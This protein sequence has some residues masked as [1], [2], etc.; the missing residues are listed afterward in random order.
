MSIVSP[1][2]VATYQALAPRPADRTPRPSPV[3]EQMLDQLRSLGYV[4]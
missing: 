2:P 1:A 4:Q 3:D